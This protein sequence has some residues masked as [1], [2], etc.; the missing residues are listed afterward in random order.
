MCILLCRFYISCF[1]AAD[2]TTVPYTVIETG[3]TVSQVSGEAELAAT[4]GAPAAI[5]GQ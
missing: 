2:R 5:A 3:I 4:G 1:Y